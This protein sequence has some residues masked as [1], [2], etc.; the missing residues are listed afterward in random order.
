MAT[1]LID[2]E[3]P[4]GQAFISAADNFGFRP[5]GSFSDYYKTYEASKPCTTF[6]ETVKRPY[7]WLCDD[8][9]PLMNDEINGANNLCRDCDNFCVMVGANTLADAK[10]TG[11]LI[12]RSKSA[13]CSK[14]CYQHCSCNRVVLFYSVY[15]PKKNR[16]GIVARCT[17][18]YE[19]K[20]NGVSNGL[21]FQLVTYLGS[22]IRDETGF[23]TDRQFYI[24]S[25]DNG[26]GSA[27]HFWENDGDVKINEI[28]FELLQSEEDICRAFLANAPFKVD[29]GGIIDL[30]SLNRELQRSIGNGEDVK[31]LYRLLKPMYGRKKAKA[32]QA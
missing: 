22:I 26:F 5:C 9:E 24:V 12:E 1:Y 7:C 15:S 4:I 19:Y 28:S 10:A 30:Q 13:V 32:K 2:Y 6:W 17:E 14:H 20:P 21:D 11:N 25:G 31:K 23:F 8:C 27:I 16:E 29:F 18:A 3:N